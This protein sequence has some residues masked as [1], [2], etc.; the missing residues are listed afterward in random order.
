MEIVRRLFD[1]K[2][3]ETFKVE[4]SQI[5]KHIESAFQDLK[6]A[7]TTFPVSDKAAYLFADLPLLTLLVRN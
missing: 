7:R 1:E 3:L 4:R 5:A 2:R 6:E